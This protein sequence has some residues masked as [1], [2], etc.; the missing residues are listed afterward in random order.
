M[1][2][3]NLPGQVQANYAGVLSTSGGLVFFGESSGGFA[4]VDAATGRYLWHF[5]TNHTMKASPMTYEV[6]RRQYV[7]IASGANI[8]SFA[9]P[10]AQ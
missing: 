2:Q 10:D 8:L 5:E 4:A 1:W 6:N 3:I 7:A 9:L